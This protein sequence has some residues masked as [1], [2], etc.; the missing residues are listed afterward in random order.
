VRCLDR[1][2]FNGFVPNWLLALFCRVILPGI[3]PLDFDLLPLPEVLGLIPPLEVL[4]LIPPLEVL[5]LIPPLEVLGL[6]E[7]LR[8]NAGLI[9]ADEL[10]LESGGGVR[11]SNL[12]ELPK[13]LGCL[14]PI[15]GALAVFT[16]LLPSKDGILPRTTG[17]KSSS[18]SSS[19]SLSLIA[20]SSTCVNATNN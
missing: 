14:D 12:P 10:T 15:I 3:R 2:E 20:E 5:G 4:G 6:I 1:A 19:S 17:A 8:D 16:A 9:S 7:L 18:L 11:G 13:K